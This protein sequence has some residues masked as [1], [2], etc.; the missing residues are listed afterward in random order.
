MAIGHVAKM[1]KKRRDKVREMY[2]AG[3]YETLEELYAVVMKRCYVGRTTAIG[4]VK[5]IREEVAQMQAEQASE[6][7]QSFGQRFEAAGHKE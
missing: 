6:K 2:H 5:A 3:G 1:I 7:P 4:D